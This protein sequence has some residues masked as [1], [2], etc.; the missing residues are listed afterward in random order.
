MTL[1]R[2]CQEVV[3]IDGVN[4]NGQVLGDIER[5]VGMGW[6]YIDSDFLSV[7]LWD[8]CSVIEKVIQWRSRIQL[9]SCMTTLAGQREGFL[10]VSTRSYTPN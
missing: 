6:I 4:K 9:S 10:N 3:E 5:G 8:I 1:P 7:G 2:K